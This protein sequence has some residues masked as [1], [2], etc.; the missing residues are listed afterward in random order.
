MA[1]N[2]TPHLTSESLVA[3]SVAHKVPPAPLVLVQLGFDGAG[4]NA[5][6][7]FMGL[8][9][10]GVRTLQAL[11]PAVDPSDETKALIKR[12]VVGMSKAPVFVALR[13]SDEGGSQ[14]IYGNRDGVMDIVDDEGNHRLQEI[15][16]VASVIRTFF[17]GY[18]TVSGTTVTCPVSRLGIDAAPL[19]GEDPLVTQMM[20]DDFPSF[21]VTVG[22]PAGGRVQILGWRSTAEHLFTIDSD[23]EEATFSGTSAEGAATTVMAAM[24]SVQAAD[25]EIS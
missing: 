4:S 8:V 20:S 18:D 22:Y 24:A 10:R 13:R 17:S 25:P 23:A 6:S 2:L 9:D 1:N 11:H 5:T 15:G 7:E 12:C 3:L 14:V 19:D 16:D 21:L